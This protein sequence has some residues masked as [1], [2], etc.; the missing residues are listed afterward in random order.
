MRGHSVDALQVNDGAGDHEQ[1]KEL[2]TVQV[3]VE[4]TGLEAFRYAQSV[5]CGA[6]RVEDT[7]REDADQR[8]AQVADR[9]P[10]LGDQPVQERKQTADGEREEHEGT[11]RLEVRLIEL[12]VQ[13]EHD[14]D[15]RKHQDEHTVED[16]RKEVAV[17]AVVDAGEE[18]A[19][20][21][22]CEVRM[23]GL[24]TEVLFN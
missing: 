18:R 2:V 1:M 7:H 11:Q 8:E 19:W 4:Q 9:E 5:Q 16:L 10:V 13:R 12:L 21:R 6:Q 22:G 3:N 17:E 24:V 14:G 15:Q 20:G 23:S